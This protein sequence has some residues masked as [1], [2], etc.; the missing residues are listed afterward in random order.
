MLTKAEHAAIAQAWMAKRATAAE[1]AR[2]F[3][4]SRQTIYNS[5]RR[6]GLQV[7]RRAKGGPPRLRALLRSTASQRDDAGAPSA[8]PASASC[9]LSRTFL[10]FPNFS[11]LPP[12]GV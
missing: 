4:C 8:P 5:L 1:L 7:G 11:P 2:R 3:G 9:W 12:I 10:E 6:Q